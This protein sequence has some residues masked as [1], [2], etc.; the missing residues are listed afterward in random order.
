LTLNELFAVGGPL[1]GIVALLGWASGA[2]LSK[3]KSDRA[4]RALAQHGGRQEVRLERESESG[5]VETTAHALRIVR[6]QMVDLR[7]DIARQ[8]RRIETLEAELETAHRQ[9]RRYRALHG[10]LP[11]RA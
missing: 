6:E 9:L 3:R 1:A 7:E 8:E 11:E 10:E 2:Y 5:I 4:D